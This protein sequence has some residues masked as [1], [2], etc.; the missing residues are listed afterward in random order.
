MIS[1]MFFYDSFIHMCGNMQFREEA[2]KTLGKSLHHSDL[3]PLEKQYAD[4]MC[5]LDE[6]P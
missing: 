4:L 5:M 2:T 3:F 6:I 1:R